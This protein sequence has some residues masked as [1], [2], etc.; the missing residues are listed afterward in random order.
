MAPS[1]TVYDDIQDGGAVVQAA[2]MEAGIASDLVRLDKRA[3]EHLT[4]EFTAEFTALNPRQQLVTLRLAD[5]SIM[6]EGVAIRIYLD[7]A[8]RDAGLLP[9]TDSPDWVQAVRG[10]VFMAVDLYFWMLLQWHGDEAWLRQTRP[11]PIALVEA[12]IVRPR[13]AP[14]HRANFGE[15]LG[16]APLAE[17]PP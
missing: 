2:L 12:V 9:P 10:P 5:G 3:G 17:L 8:H 16:C 13:I 1:D 7:A 14:L 6:T 11:K 4:P 15:G